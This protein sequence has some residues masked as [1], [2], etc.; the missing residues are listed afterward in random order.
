MTI[1]K[2]ESSHFYTREGAP[3]YDSK[4]KEIRELGH[5]PSATTILGAAN[6]WALNE[7][8]KKQVA[9]ACLLV[10]M[11]GG[12]G[13]TRPIGADQAA[14]EEEA[15]WMSERIADA[16]EVVKKFADFGSKFH[17][18][19]EAILNGDEWDREDAWLVKFDEWAQANIV[20][21]IW[22]EKCLVHPSY[23]FAGRADAYVEHQAHGAILLDFKTRKLRQ[24]KSGK[25]SAA[26]SRYDKDIR[27]LAAYSDCMDQ[28]PAVMNLYIHRDEAVEPAEYLWGS[29][30]QEQGLKAFLALANYWCLDKK[31]DPRA[32]VPAEE[33]VAA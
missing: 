32:W 6:S 26:S 23:L 15:T 31:Y 5:I 2:Q 18:G 25:Y 7:W 22:T 29:E 20:N 21:T 8:Q 12:Y 16:G 17:D 33:E 14:E 13:R 9:L 1:I 27:Q 11:P 3:A 19:A 10:P 28:K 30:A 24:L 4:M